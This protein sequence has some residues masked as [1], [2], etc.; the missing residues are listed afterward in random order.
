MSLGS[1]NTV[2][3]L[4]A[5]TLIIASNPERK[6][7]IISNYGGE[8]LFLGPDANVTTANGIPILPRDAMNL[9]GIFEG[10]RGSIYG[11]CT[12]GPVDTRYWEWIS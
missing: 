1:Y 10:F 12:T 8:P 7:I 9:I 5:A 3:V 11:I 4:S 2:S 6:G